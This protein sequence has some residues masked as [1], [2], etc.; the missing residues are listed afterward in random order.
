MAPYR[1]PKNLFLALAFKTQNDFDF[2]SFMVRTPLG[3]SLLGASLL[4]E[5]LPS[6]ASALL[7][8]K[9]VN[10]MPLHGQETGLFLMAL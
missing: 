3:F 6:P 5:S 9:V 10:G 1:S 4:P 7:L 2:T 8:R